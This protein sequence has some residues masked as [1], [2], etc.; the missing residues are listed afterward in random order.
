MTAQRPPGLSGRSRE[1]VGLARGQAVGVLSAV[2][3]PAAWFT[4]L[5]F[6]DVPRVAECL[7]SRYFS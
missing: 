2:S 3:L 7:L 1:S 4:L 5:P 6:W